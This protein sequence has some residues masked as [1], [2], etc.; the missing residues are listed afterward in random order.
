MTPISA[1]AN[2]YPAEPT[3]DQRLAQ[4]PSPEA[5]PLE[6][7]R[8]GPDLFIFKA[9]IDDRRHP[10]SGQVLPRVALEAPDWVNV[11]AVTIEGLVILVRQFRFGSG[12]VSTEIPAG[13]VD[14]G[15]Q[16]LAA[17]RR[18]LLEETGFAA[19][20]WTGLGSVDPN[21]AFLGNR[22]HLW[23]ADGC[24]KV[25]EP[26]MDGGEDIALA[27]WPLDAVRQAIRSGDIDHSLVVCAF[28]RILDL[29]RD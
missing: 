27:F 21:P 4:L 6:Q 22:C 3:L 20:R 13:M 15:E 29:S 17:A 1:S 16:P 26:Q 5:W 12:A 18:E 8:P 19:E 2:P 10:R 24:R 28:S 14:P 11:I 7:S 9:R 23:L 25:A